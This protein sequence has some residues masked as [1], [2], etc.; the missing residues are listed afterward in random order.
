MLGSIE[1]GG[2]K[3]V[4]AVGTGEG[5]IKESLTV[6]TTKPQETIGKVLD[7]L[8]QFSVEAIGVG[9]FGPIDVNEQSDTYGYITSTPKEGWR[10]Y[11]F[12]G[13]L[14]ERFSVPVAWTT[15]VNEAGFAEYKMGAA[16]GTQSCLYLTVGTGIGGGFISQG[17]LLSNFG[18]PE[19]GHILLRRHPQDSFE[20]LCP[21]HKNCLE[22][23]ASGPAVEKRWGDEGRNLADKS[24]V[25]QLEAYYL[26]QA[27]VSYTMI[28][29]PERMILGGG[30]M[31]Q[32]K[33]FP[34]IREQFHKMLGD[35]LE[36]PELEN[37]IQPVGLHDQAGIIG[38][39]LLARDRVKN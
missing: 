1:A 9:S 15:D 17:Q 35:Y 10:N 25:W 36:V 34:L 33:L 13:A 16:K 31:K 21:Y 22:G 24:E 3:F 2:T 19:M 20:G 23:M 39:L 4:V 5:Q 28:L 30:L 8:S 26:A 29:R 37:Y 7:F 18:H 11:N 6:P 12:V 32:K 38:G 27:L 14:K